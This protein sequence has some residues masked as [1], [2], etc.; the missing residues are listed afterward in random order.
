MYWTLCEDLWDSGL[1]RAAKELCS[2]KGRRSPSGQAAKSL[3]QPQQT[4]G[5]NDWAPEW[6]VTVVLEQ[7]PVTRERISL[8]QSIA[9]LYDKHSQ[10]V[11][12]EIHRVC[13]I[14]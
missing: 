2:Q 14:L 4:A 12:D 3:L 6:E 7:V 10:K 1:V 9:A 13:F 8:P 11:F 5:V